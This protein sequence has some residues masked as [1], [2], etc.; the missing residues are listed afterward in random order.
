MVD[1][2]KRY[3]AAYDYFKHLST[4]SLAG[5]VLIGT[6]ITKL[7]EMQG[8]EFLKYSIISFVLT[9]VLTTINYTLAI[10]DHP[11]GKGLNKI[12]SHLQGTALFIN[13]CS[14][15]CAPVCLGLF[16]LANLT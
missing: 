7:S 10:M 9:I 8:I 12:L 4:L 1:R 15:L 6:F 13:W 14:I 5:L 16:C 3:D 11:T 2:T